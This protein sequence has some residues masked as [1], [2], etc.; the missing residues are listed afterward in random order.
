MTITY[1]PLNIDDASQYRT[2][3]LEGLKFHPESFLESYESAVKLPLSAIEENFRERWNSAHNLVFG[4]FQEGKLVGTLGM[5]KDQEQMKKNHKMT[6]WGVMVQESMRGKGIAKGLMQMALNH[7]RSLPE[8]TRLELGVES[9][10]LSAK[11]L[12]QS[13]GFVC[14]GTEPDAMIV[15][16]K[17]FHEDYMSLK[18]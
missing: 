5:W 10:N 3:R 9:N 2:L 16:G 14:W 13:F 12:Y 7:A 11:S 1:R 18:L 17:S 15:D 4:A 8:I 6:I